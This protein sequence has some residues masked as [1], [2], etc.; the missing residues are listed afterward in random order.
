MILKIFIIWLV[1]GEIYYT[2]TYVTR[3][4]MACKNILQE[5]QVHI[6]GSLNFAVF[7]SCHLVVQTRGSGQNLWYK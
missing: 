4:F 6:A 2:F 7:R 1:L 5:N 3:L